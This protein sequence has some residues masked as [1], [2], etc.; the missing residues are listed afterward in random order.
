MRTKIVSAILG[1]AAIIGMLFAVAPAAQAQS[2]NVVQQSAQALKGPVCEW[3]SICGVLGNTG[4]VGIG[5]VANWTSNPRYNMILQPNDW[6][7]YYYQDTDGFYVGPG[8][9]VNTAPFYPQR[10]PRYG[11]YRQGYH[12]ITD[13]AELKIWAYR[14]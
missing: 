11:H 10:N 6:S 8:Y 7:S 1:F 13:S 2:S 9:C 3:T 5:I 14:C 4:S 12:K